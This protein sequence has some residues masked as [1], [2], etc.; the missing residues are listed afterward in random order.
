MEKLQEIKDN[1][2]IKN[3][4]ESFNKFLFDEWLDQ[5]GM[6][7]II[8]EVVIEYSSELL[9]QNMEMK[10]ALKKLIPNMQGYA[11]EYH[12]NHRWF[13]FHFKDEIELLKTIT[14]CN[15]GNE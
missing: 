9:R 3:G 1:I 4:Y 2:A 6:N 10:E 13:E 12:K 8:D 11:Y 5:D 14:S 7:P 15:K